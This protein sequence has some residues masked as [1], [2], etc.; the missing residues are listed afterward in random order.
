MSEQ[1]IGVPLVPGSHVVVF[2]DVDIDDDGGFAGSLEFEGVVEQHVPET[3]KLSFEDSD[4]GYATFE[5]LLREND[6]VQ[7][8]SGD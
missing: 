3:R 2:S 1:T 8:I 6:G 5:E 4:V 7:V